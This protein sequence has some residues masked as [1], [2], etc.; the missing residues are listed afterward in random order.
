MEDTEKKILE[1]YET[2]PSER[3]KK[4]LGDLAYT[5]KKQTVKKTLADE[6]RDEA[7]WYEA[8]WK[9]LSNHQGTSAGLLSPAAL[10][11]A[12]VGSFEIIET[13]LK[14]TDLKALPIPKRFQ[15]FHLL[16]QMLVNYCKK[17]AEYAGVPLSS[18]Y[19]M[20]NIHLVPALFESQFP[21]Y[22]RSGVSLTAFLK[23]VT[24]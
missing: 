4:L 10:R 3:K 15:I 13:F 9:A 1:L 6:T 2:L 16:A 7:L 24:P 18:K 19:V 5:S 20:N 14:D 22:S 21:G 11:A 17:N 8:L 23:F 12:R